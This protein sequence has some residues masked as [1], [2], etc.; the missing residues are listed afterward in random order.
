MFYLSFPGPFIFCI[1]VSL[2]M[3][4][5]FNKYPYNQISDKYDKNAS[6]KQLMLK[7]HFHGALLCSDT[8]PILIRRLNSQSLSRI[9]LLQIIPPGWDSQEAKFTR[10]DLKLRFIHK[11]QE[12]CQPLK[13]NAELFVCVKCGCTCVHR[14]GILGQRSIDFITFSQVSEAQKKILNHYQR[15]FFG[16]HCDHKF[17]QY[18][19]DIKI[20]VLLNTYI[21]GGQ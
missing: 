1:Y 20:L 15:Q 18:F 9:Y 6:N 10:E 21:Q 5:H 14:C 8:L 19:N 7:M 3:Q 16:K 13:L 4:P 17:N 2:Q 11:L 12:I